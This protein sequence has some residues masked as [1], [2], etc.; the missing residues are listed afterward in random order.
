M[1]DGLTRVLRSPLYDQA[2]IAL[3]NLELRRDVLI[4]VRRP[5]VMLG[6]ASRHFP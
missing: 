5:D 3:N 1:S 6:L 4:R 2:G